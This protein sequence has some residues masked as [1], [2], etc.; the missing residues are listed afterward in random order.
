[1]SVRIVVATVVILAAIVLIQRGDRHAR[2]AGEAVQ[3][4]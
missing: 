2:D 4:D 3:S 1:M